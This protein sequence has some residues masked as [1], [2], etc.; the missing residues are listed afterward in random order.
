MSM[1][2]EEQV[3]QYLAHWFQVGKKVLLHNGDETFDLAVIIKGEG[4]SPEFEAFWEKVRASTKD[5]YL[6]GTTQTI[7]ELLSDHW[8]V[9]A[10]ARCQMPVPLMVAGYQAVLCPCQDLGLWPNDT[11]P[12]PHCPV[13]TYAHLRRIQSRLGRYQPSPEAEEETA[14]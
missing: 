8:E 10:C 1:A 11:V 7:R 13:Q 2:S 3:K 12:P 5:Y 14:T 6:E 9:L 4:Y